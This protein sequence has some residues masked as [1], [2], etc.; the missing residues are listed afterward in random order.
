MGEL[1][2]IAVQMLA[3]HVVAHAIVTT[4][5]QSPETL[6]A[7]GVNLL[8]DVFANGVIHRLVAVP[9]QTLIGTVVV[10]EYTASRCCVRGNE[11][12]KG[13]AASCP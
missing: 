1:G 10:G 8:I 6:N 12:L 11:T 3:A 9:D 2:N 4:L 7:V 5:E 13:G